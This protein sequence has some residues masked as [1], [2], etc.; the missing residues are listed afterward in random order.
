MTYLSADNDMILRREIENREQT[1]KES[2]AQFLT[3]IESKC[4]KLIK[5]LQADEKLFIIRRNLNTF[6]TTSIAA[7]NVQSINHLIELCRLVD[8]YGKTATHCTRY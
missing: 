5:P 4:Q 1:Q 6:Y 3:D 8:T 7:H 2:F